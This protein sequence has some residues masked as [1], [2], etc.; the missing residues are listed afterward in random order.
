M[1]ERPEDKEYRERQDARSG[2]CSCSEDA[3]FGGYP[4]DG[5]CDCGIYKHH[6]HCGRCGK[7]VQIG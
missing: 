2:W 3:T 6:I 5:E 1:S 4:K 7:I